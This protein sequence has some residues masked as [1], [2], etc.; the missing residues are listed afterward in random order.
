MQGN[1][2]SELEQQKIKEANRNPYTDPEFYKEVVSF[3][4]NE[5]ETRKEQRKVTELKWQL[6]YN[7]YKGNQHCFID[8]YK[9]KIIL[10]DLENENINNSIYNNI[11]PIVDT[12]RAQLRQLNKN[13]TVL[14]ATSENEDII[15]AEISSHILKN[16]YDKLKFDK[17]LVLASDWAEITGTAFIKSCWDKYAGEV[18]GEVEGEVLRQG[19]I[20]TSVVSCFEIYPENLEKENLYDQNS[21]I[22]AKLMSRDEIFKKYGI[23]ISGSSN[24]IYNFNIECNLN[25][26]SEL[27]YLQDSAIVKEYYDLPDRFYPNGRFITV[28]ED[29]M[30]V[31]ASLPF[32]N[33]D[34]GNRTFPFVKIDCIR[35]PGQFFSDS[36][37]ERLISVQESYNNTN[38]AINTFLD[39]TA[40]GVP[41]IEEDSVE[42][43]ED[44][45]NNGFSP[46]QLIILKNGRTAPR[47]LQMN[48]LPGE[49]FGMKKDLENSFNIISG[50][51]EISRNSSAPAGVNSGVGIQLLQQQEDTRISL[52]GKNILDALGE[53]GQQWLYLY[54]QFATTSRVVRVTGINYSISKQWTK[55]IITSFDVKVADDNNMFSNSAMTRELAVN[56]RDNGIINQDKYSKLM[57]V[58]VFQNGDINKL[59]QNE[60]LDIKN[61]EKENYKFKDN[62]ELPILRNEDDHELHLQVH[63]HLRKGDWFR[64]YLYEKEPEL[65]E[66]FN[67][68]CKQH[69]IAIDSMKQ[70]ECNQ[71]S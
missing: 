31:Y 20:S 32:I 10:K 68:H 16:T 48:N 56:F 30:P 67:E 22:H 42:N 69:Q 11:A 45:V 55:D 33:S 6:Y 12:R 18:A 64:D 1:E 51:S 46:G 5:F 58:S 38:N 70:A 57:F 26:N 14:S 2:I 35:V 43:E 3:V 8:N 29:K 60:F 50:V 59:F 34:N 15:N 25:N 39:Y 9:N 4:T 24:E 44:I 52:T 61:A 54:K 40:I 41:I 65:A 36:I 53:I 23:E 63:N 49:F 7:F 37:I 47:F 21:L 17:D 28:I 71:N 19:E 13:M 62:K 66:Q 27:Q